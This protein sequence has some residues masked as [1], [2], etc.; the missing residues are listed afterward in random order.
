MAPLFTTAQNDPPKPRDAVIHT[1]KAPPITLYTSSFGGFATQQAVLQHAAQMVA[2]L[3]AAGTEVSA[4]S[5]WFASYD[6]P[7][8]YTSF[9][10]LGI[11]LCIRYYIR[12]CLGGWG[13]QGDLKLLALMA[14][15]CSESTRI[16]LQI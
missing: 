12:L 14:I 11:R 15:D 4:K 5:F 7:Y 2:D 16:H 3:K 9:Y 13:W 1:L 8:R 10:I 6:P